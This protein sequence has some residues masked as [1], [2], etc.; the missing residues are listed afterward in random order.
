MNLKKLKL[1]LNLDY[2]FSLFI[3]LTQNS[4]KLIPEYS[5]QVRSK[6]HQRNP[7]WARLQLVMQINKPLCTNHEKC[8][9]N[10]WTIIKIDKILFTNSSDSNYAILNSI[11]ILLNILCARTWLMYDWPRYRLRLLRNIITR[12]IRLVVFI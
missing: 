3:T 2:P 10:I 6:H 5:G 9:K 7:D 12:S 11:R 8:S 1:S 4:T